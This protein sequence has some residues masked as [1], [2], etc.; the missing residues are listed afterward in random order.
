LSRAVE[1]ISE[2]NAI[3]PFQEGNGR[4]LRAFLECLADEV[5]LRIALQ[6]I[7]P[8]AWIDVSICG[9]RDGY[10]EPMRRV[11]D[12]AVIAADWGA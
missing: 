9:F 11:I 7:D 10:H 8:V 3:H 1:H 4:T 6:R 12:T 5:G 2:I